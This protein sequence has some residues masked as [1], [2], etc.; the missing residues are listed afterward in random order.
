MKFPSSWI[1]S[2]DSL[3]N[4]VNLKSTV[5]HFTLQHLWRVD[6]MLC[7]YH[8]KIKLK[9][10]WISSFLTVW[11]NSLTWILKCYKAWTLT[12]PPNLSGTSPPPT[13]LSASRTTCPLT[14]CWLHPTSHPMGRVYV[15]SFP[16]D[17]G[18]L[19]SVLVFTTCPSDFI[20]TAL[21]DPDQIKSP[22]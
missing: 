12:T 18:I 4:D 3:Y 17:L 10:K 19:S 5:V 7:S 15:L 14:A 16:S 11:G 20:W 9:I 13:Q 21:P 1:S 8:N 2:T 6:L 22:P